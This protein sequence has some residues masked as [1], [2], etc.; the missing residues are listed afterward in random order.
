M[1]TKVICALT[2][3]S[4]QSRQKAGRSIVFNRT[5]HMLLS[6]QGMLKL[7]SAFKSKTQSSLTTWHVLTSKRKQEAAHLQNRSV[8][9]PQTPTPAPKGP[10]FQFLKLVQRVGG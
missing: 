2:F 9:N 10:Y 3:T 8:G 6:Q 1:K 4:S 7:R 5:L